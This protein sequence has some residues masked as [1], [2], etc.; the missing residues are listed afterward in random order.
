V[1][2]VILGPCAAISF[3]PILLD[4]QKPPS[5]HKFEA[6]IFKILIKSDE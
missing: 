4:E 5:L 3:L 1:L 2:I 6:K